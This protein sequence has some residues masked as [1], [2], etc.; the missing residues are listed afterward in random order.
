MKFIQIEQLDKCLTLHFEINESEN[1]FQNR[2]SGSSLFTEFTKL[3]GNIKLTADKSKLIAVNIEIGIANKFVLS[4]YSIRL[5]WL[6]KYKKKLSNQITV[7]LHRGSDGN[8]LINK[9][10][11]TQ[12][13]RKQNF[14]VIYYLIR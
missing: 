3:K 6:I 9:S 7:D 4:I 8:K 2:F 12:H 5:V 10:E 13:N 1:R 11:R 14:E